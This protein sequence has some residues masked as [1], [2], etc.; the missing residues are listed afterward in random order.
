LF[1]HYIKSLLISFSQMALGKTLK[2]P[3]SSHDI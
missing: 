3:N 1:Y 2:Y